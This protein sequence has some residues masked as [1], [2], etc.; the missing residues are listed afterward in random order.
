MFEPEGGILRVCAGSIHGPTSDT[1]T[2]L[3][4]TVALLDCRGAHFNFAVEGVV[5]VTPAIGMSTA[6]TVAVSPVPLKGT[7]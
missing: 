5:A 6:A 2:E 1:P 3:G 7:Q 4:K